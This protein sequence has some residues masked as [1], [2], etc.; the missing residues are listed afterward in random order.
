MGRD[1]LMRISGG[2]NGGTWSTN[3]DHDL[4][5]EDGISST[6]VL[7]KLGCAFPMKLVDGFEKISIQKTGTPSPRE[8][9]SPK[10]Q[11]SPKERIKREI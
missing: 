1:S 3:R 7:V 11:G 9:V 6:I 2:S 5:G 4:G 10:G 8:R